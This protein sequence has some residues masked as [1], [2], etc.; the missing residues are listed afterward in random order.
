VKDCLLSIEREFFLRL[1][2]GPRGCEGF[3][4]DRLCE[5]LKRAGCEP[6]VEQRRRAGKFR[7]SAGHFDL[8]WRFG[9][10]T[11]A[12]ELKFCEFPR[13]SKLSNSQVLYDAG[14]LLW[15]AIGIEESPYEFGYVLPI[16][17]TRGVYPDWS[18]VAL[19]R[20]FHNSMFCDLEQSKRYGE[21]RLQND[22]ARIEQLRVAEEFGWDGPFAAN[23]R[24]DDFIAAA[25]SQFAAIGYFV[26][27]GALVRGLK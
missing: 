26:R 15:D 8:V 9:Q 20:A 19:K 18:A 3:V 6:V 12:V 7:S 5:F 25:S 23:S 17:Y 24:V 13:T 14:Q 16:L 10:L 1:A 11:G 27:G 21:L 2:D 22:A 4:R